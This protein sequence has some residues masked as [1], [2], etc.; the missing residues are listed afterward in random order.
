MMQIFF[1]IRYSRRR[2]GRPTPSPSFGP[3]AGSLTQRCPLSAFCTLR[4]SGESRLQAID[5]FLH[6]FLRQRLEQ[7][8]GE[9]GEFSENLRGAFPRNLG[10]SGDGR[11]L[12]TSAHV[13][14]TAGDAALAGVERAPGPFGLFE[15]HL[16]GGGAANVRDAHGD[17]DD[18]VLVV[19][20]RH[21][22]IIRKQRAEALGVD[23]EVED[24]LGLAR[25]DKI[26][27]ECEGHDGWFPVLVYFP[28]AA[29]AV[30]I[31][32]KMFW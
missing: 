3:R 17:V 29:A 12:E 24:L 30:R 26:S 19:G 2:T 10:A 18:E 1:A 14:I 31:A 22:L 9:R 13:H 32:F 28:P 21:A 25:D 11:K 27:G 15:R 23:E 8:A 4:A 16:D 6:T 7:A 5:Q 20:H